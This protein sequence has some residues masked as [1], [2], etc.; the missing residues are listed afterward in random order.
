MTWRTAMIS[1]ASVTIGISKRTDPCRAST[2]SAARN[3]VR[4]RSGCASAV[5][6]PRIPSA[7][8]GSG[9][10]GK[11]SK[12]LSPPTSI[13]RRIRGRPPERVGDTLIG[14]RAV[15][16]PS[17]AVARSMN[18]NS[19]RSSPQPSA[20]FSTAARR[21]GGVAQIREHFD[22][23]A[24]ERSAFG[25]RCRALRGAAREPG[26]NLRLRRAPLRSALG[27]ARCSVPLSAST[28]TV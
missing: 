24:V 17:G 28:M 2:R 25:N 12:G 9:G 15:R 26:R 3:W 6:T 8:F 21:V 20:P 14:R 16:L 7:G 23:R 4:I 10:S 22:P 11:Y 13:I 27:G 19:V 18:R 5:R 1:A